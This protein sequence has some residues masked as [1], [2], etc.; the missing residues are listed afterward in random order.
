MRPEICLNRCILEMRLDGHEFDTIAVALAECAVDM[1]VAAG[2]REAALD[3]GIEE[4]VDAIWSHAARLRR[5][6]PAARPR[7]T[8]VQGLKP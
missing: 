3:G 6:H 7:L 1:L 8:L 5:H 4:V 2:F